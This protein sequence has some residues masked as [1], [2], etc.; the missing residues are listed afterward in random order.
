MDLEQYLERVRII[1][2]L[3][4]RGDYRNLGVRRFINAIFGTEEECE[5]FLMECSREDIQAILVEE[6]FDLDKLHERFE[7]EMGR[8]KARYSFSDS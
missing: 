2:F 3:E 7:E 1:R 6:G 8:I 4:N 5:K